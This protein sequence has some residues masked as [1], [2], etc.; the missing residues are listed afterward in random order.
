MNSTRAPSRPWHL[1]TLLALTILLPSMSSA[2][3]SAE[4]T[5]AQLATL[6]R[7]LA[8]I[9][10]WITEN[11]EDQAALDRAL[12]QADQALNNQAQATRSNRMGARRL[13]RLQSQRGARFL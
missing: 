11:A 1:S 13:V 3:P 2:A 10:R 7:E 6:K 12:K 8:E 5:S 4:A 9:E